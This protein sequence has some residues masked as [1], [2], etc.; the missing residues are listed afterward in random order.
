MSHSRC[1]A[2]VPHGLSCGEVCSPP[3]AAGVRARFS[4]TSNK[5]EAIIAQRKGRILVIPGRLCIMWNPER[6][7]EQL[8]VPALIHCSRNVSIY[9]CNVG[10]AENKSIPCSPGDKSAEMKG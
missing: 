7:L 3:Q 10:F 2:C 5:T 1:D 4:D 9:F 6:K 8:S